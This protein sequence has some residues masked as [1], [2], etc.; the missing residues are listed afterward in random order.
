MPIDELA[1]EMELENAHRR[2]HT[3]IIKASVTS[4]A[5]ICDCIDQ[6]TTRREYRPST[7][8]TYS[9][10]AVVHRYVKSATHFRLGAVP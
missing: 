8:A 1:C 6:S 4:C 5:V 3:A 2:R 9:Q 10:P 7:T